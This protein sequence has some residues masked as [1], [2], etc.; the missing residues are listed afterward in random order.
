MLLALL[1]SHHSRGAP[2]SRGSTRSVPWC[3]Q[4]SGLT[5]AQRRAT[6][7]GVTWSGGRRS[8][9]QHDEPVLR[10][11]GYSTQSP[12]SRD[13]NT[14]CLKRY[15]AREIYAALPRPSSPSPTVLA[16]PEPTTPSV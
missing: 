13:A 11:R 3:A 16:I 5:D 14:G 1:T 2:N 8:K 10:H 4:A 7:E 9:G 15:I 12:A 6:T